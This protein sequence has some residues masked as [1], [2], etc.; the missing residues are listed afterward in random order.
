MDDDVAVYL[1]DLLIKVI[2]HLKTLDE[3]VLDKSTFV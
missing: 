3:Q 1:A 2:S